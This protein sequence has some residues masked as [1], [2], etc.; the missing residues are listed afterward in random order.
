MRRNWL[1]GIRLSSLVL[2]LDI[3]SARHHERG[4]LSATLLA[5]RQTSG[6]VREIT[7]SPPGS[8]STHGHRRRITRQFFILSTGH[9]GRGR[10]R[11]RCSSPYRVRCHTAR[12]N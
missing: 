3:D 6:D 10:A 11:P 5:F 7:P 4:A 2:A 8:N 1:N 9:A 12:V